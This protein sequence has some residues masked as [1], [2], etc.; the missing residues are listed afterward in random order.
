MNP[1][2]VRS[3]ELIIQQNEKQVKTTGGNATENEE[4]EREETAFK[5]TYV[6]LEVGVLQTAAE[7]GL[8]QETKKE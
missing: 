4:H 7:V 8:R 6:F 1:A 3:K 5:E 2:I